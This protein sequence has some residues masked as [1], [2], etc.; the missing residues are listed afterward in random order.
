[1]NFVLLYVQYTL[2]SH[3]NKVPVLTVCINNIIF[4]ESA[5][6]FTVWHALKIIFLNR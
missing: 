2:F 4:I 1:M 5:I 6:N 3:A